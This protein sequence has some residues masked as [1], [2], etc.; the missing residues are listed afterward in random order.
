MV[1]KKVIVIVLIIAIL[2]AAFS[3]IT[4][5]SNS[6]LESKSLVSGNNVQSDVQQAQVSIIVN[7]PSHAPN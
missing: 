6:N 1:S 7:K 2:M 5:I 4:A 3:I